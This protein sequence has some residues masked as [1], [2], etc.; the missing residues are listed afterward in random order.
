[1]NF[2][3]NYSAWWRRLA[4]WHAKLDLGSIVDVKSTADNIYDRTQAENGMW[5]HKK[6][7]AKISCSCKAR[8][9]VI[10]IAELMG[11]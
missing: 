9:W 2:C 6:T 10:L 8:E 4:F 3:P 1:M 7:S 11:S 5:Q